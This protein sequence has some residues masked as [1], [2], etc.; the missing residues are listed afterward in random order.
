MITTYIRYGLIAVGLLII[1]IIAV[2]FGLQAMNAT[3]E[4]NEYEYG[5]NELVFTIYHVT[6]CPYCKQAL[7]IWH[8]IKKDYHNTKTVTGKTIIL[9]EVDCTNMSDNEPIVNGGL[10]ESFPTI[11][12]NNNIDEQTEFTSK[13]TL[14]TLKTF[15][16]DMVKEN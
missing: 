16:D 5:G 4:N 8:K 13:C 14:K 2:H 1:T 9:N 3:K 12:F 11:Y 6:W 15:I 10:I 7:P